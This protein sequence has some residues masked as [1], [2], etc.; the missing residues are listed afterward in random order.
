MRYYS[1]I[2][3]VYNRPQEVEELL[4]TLT[5]QSYQNFE[6]LIIEDGSQFT[7]E[8]VVEKFT[9][10][11]DI[12]YY[13]K[14]NSGQGFTRNYG[15]ERANGDYFIIFDSDCLI[16]PHYLQAVNE[17]IDQE[18][19]DCFGGPDRAHDSF[20]IIQKAIN[21]S[22]TSPFTTGGIRG[23]KKHIGQFNPRSF[24]M[25][26]SR[27]VYKSVGGFIITRM[28]EDLEYSIRIIK[29]G[30]KTGLIPR[31]YVFHKRRTNLVQFFRQ[32]HFFGRA[33]INLSRFYPGELKF[34]HFFPAI[35]TLAFASILLF[36]WWYFPLFIS[37]IVAFTF[38]FLVIF[39]DSAFKNKSLSVAAL[40]ILSAFIQLTAYGTG[41]MREL[42]KKI[43]HK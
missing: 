13:F 21:Y 42:G 9:E 25:G 28:A 30:F 11:L 32:L 40:S 3:P 12:T 36:Y 39:I 22:M 1:I 29:A 23:N 37:G 18:H 14:E 20:T 15:F 4:E 5:R 2:I 38:F 7:C 19:W 27:Q 33:R 10:K 26:L 16:P 8:D 34:V 17:A 31:A 6:V 43:T 35:F 41:F 24:N